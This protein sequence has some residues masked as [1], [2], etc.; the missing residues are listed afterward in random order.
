M[1]NKNYDNED[2]VWRTIGGRRVFIRNGQSLADAM[3]ESGKFSRVEKNKDKYGN[4]EENSMYID[5][6]IADLDAKHANKQQ[7]EWSKQAKALEESIIKDQE[8]GNTANRMKA[9]DDAQ[10]Y[11]RLY[12][13]YEEQ[14]YSEKEIK[15]R[16]GERPK[17]GLEDI[18][19]T[20]KQI[21]AGERL[22]K[23]VEQ[24]AREDV[25]QYL[26]SDKADFDNDEEFVN[27]LS[28][29]WGIDRKQ[30]KRLLKEGK[31]IETNKSTGQQLN[32]LV[33]D[34]NVKTFA[35]EI[36]EQEKAKINPATGKPIHKLGQLNETDETVDISKSN[37]SN[38]FDKHEKER[39]E[40]AKDIAKELNPSLKN[41]SEERLNKEAKRLLEAPEG[42]T[43]KGETFYTNQKG[44]LERSTPSLE[45]WRDELKKTSEKSN[46]G[47][48]VQENTQH[49][50]TR[51]YSAEEVKQMEE[52]GVR[53]MKRSYSGYGW[54][55]VNSRQNLTTSEQAKAITD[56]MKKKYPD[57]KVARKSDV[58]SGGSSI[59]FN[60]M[61]SDKDIF[62]SEKDIDKL[63]NE[64]LYNTDITRG[65]G[66]DR[67]AEDNVPSY[68]TEHTYSVDDVKR[69]A[70]EQLNYARTHENQN[71]T[72][73]EW[74]LNDYGKKVVS[75]LNKE[76]NSYTYDDSDGMID[77]FNHGTYM[78]VS[79]GKWN[80]PYEV[81]GN[82]ITSAL[83]NKAYQ[84]YMKEHPGSKMTL[85]DFKKSQ[86]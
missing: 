45:K 67:W 14:G 6:K 19:L 73:K 8:T 40:I 31:S 75:D 15:D 13:R 12:N 18:G 78:S 4:Q 20:E 9:I 27:A 51:E 83:K 42:A 57:V 61:S 5:S 32:D 70:K 24:G 17:T 64:Q 52:N 65:Y 50:G 74:Y 37:S 25:S 54:E 49:G 43:E 3:K 63:G 33:K 79:I 7:K 26:R 58:Y 16:L 36:K 35:D 85:T 55:G 47:G 11:D 60:I 81:K 34:N 84:K 53:P 44:E 62:I 71:V 46:E 82:S 30:A 38:Y 66:F 2:G 72:G 23:K 56:T 22:S 76:A 77:Y 86:K 68:R 1:A 48:F 69:Y 41:A 29:E 28:D 10:R 39:L 80:K 59:D 21:E